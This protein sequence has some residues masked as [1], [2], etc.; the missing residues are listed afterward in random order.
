MMM[1]RGFLILLLSLWALPV[2]VFADEIL[3]DGTAQ[4]QD[5]ENFMRNREEEERVTGI[6]YMISGA[7]ATLGGLVGYQSSQDN[8]SRSAYAIAQSVGIGALGYGASIYW[9][10]NEYDSF[11]RAVRGS[12]LTPMQKNELLAR[13]LSNEKSERRRARW[14]RVGTHTLLAVVNFYAASQESNRDVRNLLQFMGGVNAVIAF[15]YSF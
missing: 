6:S 12:S 2:T 10:G 8:F 3:Y 4:W 1:K 5:F 11:Y 7:V 9:N 14:I 15:S 13:F